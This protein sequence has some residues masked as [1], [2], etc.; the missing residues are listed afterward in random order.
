[1][2]RFRLRTVILLGL[3]ALGLVVAALLLDGSHLRTSG[4]IVALVAFAAAQSLLAR[5]VASLVGGLSID[6]VSAW[7]LP[8]L[9]VWPAAMFRPILVLNDLVQRRGTESAVA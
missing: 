7:V 1:M 3:A 4:F 8:S 9:A 2:I 5:V 6:G